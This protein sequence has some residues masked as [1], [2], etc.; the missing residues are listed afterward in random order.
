MASSETFR[1]KLLETISKNPGL[2]FRELQRRTGSAVGKLDYHLYQLER[3]GRI[4][5]RKEGGNTRFFSNESG[6]V[7]DRKI[8]YYLRIKFGKD[9]LVGT[10]SNK[11]YNLSSNLSEKQKLILRDMENDG[12]IT[13]TNEDSQIRV[14]LNDRQAI[15]KFL[16]NYG[17]SFIDSIELSIL[18]LIDE[19]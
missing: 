17:Q 3:K 10:L 9:L 19:D 8:A 7:S 1:E 18:G 6:T 16:K 14:V 5:S 11:D 13:I 12:L 15:I 4:V 2:H